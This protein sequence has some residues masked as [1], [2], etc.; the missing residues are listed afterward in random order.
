M[1][2]WLH[3]QRLSVL[4]YGAPDQRTMPT[5]PKSAVILSRS[6]MDSAFFFSGG[7]A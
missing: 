2:V 7:S 6:A 4:L 5:P 1:T 3:E